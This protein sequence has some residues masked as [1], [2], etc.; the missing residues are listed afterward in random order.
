MTNEES[1]IPEA[2]AERRCY[3]R[4]DNGAQCRAWKVKMEMH[5]PYHVYR[6]E[7]SHALDES[8]PVAV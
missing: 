1:R 8:E 6:G 3:W 5:C 7:L 2:P 4:Y